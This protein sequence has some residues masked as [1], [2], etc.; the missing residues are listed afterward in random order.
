MMYGNEQV[1]RT[2]DVYALENV[3]SS[4]LEHEKA[5]KE[6]KKHKREEHLGELGAV[7]AGAFAFI[8]K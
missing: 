4:E 2:A 8:L 3:N 7:A 1:T 6:E 5:L